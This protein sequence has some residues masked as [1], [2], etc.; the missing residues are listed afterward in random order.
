MQIKVDS[1]GMVMLKMQNERIAAITVAD[2]SRM[3]QRINLT[4]SGIYNKKQE[5]VICIP[6][7]AKRETLF[8]IDLP[9]GVWIGSS[10][11]L[12]L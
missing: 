8:V 4:V 11:T 5:G 6:D 7:Q 1:Q 12:E 10:L 9:Q 3:L 2:P